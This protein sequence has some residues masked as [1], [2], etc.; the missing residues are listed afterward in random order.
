MRFKPGQQVVCV[1]KGKPFHY[2]F[3]P[4]YNEV[5]TVKGYCDCGCTGYVQLKEYLSPRP[6]EE[7]S[8]A[9]LIH[10]VVQV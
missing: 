6:G 10:E 4:E 7:I 1:V 5:V 3:G 8:Y 2:K 9:L